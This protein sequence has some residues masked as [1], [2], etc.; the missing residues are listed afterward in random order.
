LKRNDL[1]LA[2]FPNFIDDVDKEGGYCLIQVIKNSV[3]LKESHMSSEKVILDNGSTIISNS[4]V[5]INGTTYPTANITAVTRRIKKEKKGWPILMILVGFVLFSDGMIGW[6]L[7][8]LALGILLLLR[9]A[10]HF[11][12]FST[13]GNEVPVFKSK[14]ENWVVELEIAINRAIIARG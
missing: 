6:G 4:R 8:S 3:N 11:L 10:S 1:I 2:V 14:D 7:A 12:V 13:A 5:V 9:K